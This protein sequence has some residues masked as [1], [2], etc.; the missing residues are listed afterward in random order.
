M[1]EKQKHWQLQE[2]KNRFSSLVEQAQHDG[3]QIVTRHGRETV[4]VISA[5][6][7]RRLIKPKEDII[8][9]FQESPLVGEDIDLT[10]TP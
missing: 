1:L 2:A 8:R 7:Y 10:T 6:E 9:F 3:P 5:D 4:V